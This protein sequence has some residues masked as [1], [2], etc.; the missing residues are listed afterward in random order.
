MIRVLHHNQ[1]V[2]QPWEVY[3]GRP[4]PLGNPFSPVATR[5]PTFR[6]RDRDEAIANYRAW[7]RERIQVGDV[8]V[9]K[10]LEE[11]KALYVQHQ[12]LDLICWCH[13][14]PC[15]ASILREYLMKGTIDDPG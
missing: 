10:A 8:K 5:I 14:K 4:S 6:V 15:H 3:V 13:P 11:L 7:L 2:N 12:K 1:K 9:R